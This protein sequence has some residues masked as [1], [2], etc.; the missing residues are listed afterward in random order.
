MRK[1]FVIFA[2]MLA[3]GAFG[4]GCAKKDTPTATVMMFFDAARRGDPAGLAETLSFER[5]YAQMAGDAA[6]NIP[7]EKK[8]AELAKFRQVM[9]DGIL[10]GKKS[11]FRDADPKVKDER[12]SGGMAE[13]VV[14][15]RKDKGRV[16]SFGLV[17]EEGRWK[18]FK[19]AI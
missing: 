19:V 13:V 11:S 10:N 7:P 18:I 16:Y 2:V 17:R 14:E 15:D 4:L 6:L 9:L 3:V 12:I 8:A 1:T 5:L